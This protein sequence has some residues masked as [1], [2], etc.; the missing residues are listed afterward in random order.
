MSHLPIFPLPRGDNRCYCNVVLQLL[1]SIP[2]FVDFIS[3][4]TFKFSELQKIQEIYNFIIQNDRTALKDRNGKFVILI[5]DLISIHFQS[6]PEFIGKQ[7][8]SQEFL[9]SILNLI[10]LESKYAE[11]FINSLFQLIT[12]N[13]FSYGEKTD[14]KQL[15]FSLPIIGKTLN[16]IISKT[17][18]TETCSGINGM[19]TRTSKIT[20]T[21]PFLIFHIC[22]FE[23]DNYNKR[24]WKKNL[25]PISFS[26]NMKVNNK[27][28]NAKAIINHIGNSKNR[29]HYTIHLKKNGIWYLIDDDFVKCEHTHTH[30]LTTAASLLVH[31]LK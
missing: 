7:N 9:I 28:Y 18:A 23:T 10:K 24:Y 30:L 5:N 25:N 1:F 13:Y 21:G 20:Y 2:D 16:E 27:T 19:F 26:E 15:N 22:R 6:S 3:N 14:D 12:T 17:E 29:G 8:D 11:G 31:N 4:Q